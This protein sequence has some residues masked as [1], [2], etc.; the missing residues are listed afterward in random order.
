MKEYKLSPEAI[1]MIAG[2]SAGT[3]PKYYDKG[4]WYKADQNGYESEAEHLASLV[5]SCSNIRDHVIYD[6]VIE[7]LFM[8][9][10]MKNMYTTIIG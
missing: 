6:A 9:T 1:V 7:I 3:Q 5:L 8:I 10:L 2:S 4:Y